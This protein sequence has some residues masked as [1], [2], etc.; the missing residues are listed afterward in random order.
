MILDVVEYFLDGLKMRSTYAVCIKPYISPG[1][2]FKIKIN[3]F[4]ARIPLCRSNKTSGKGG[5]SE[6]ECWS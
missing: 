4:N 5:S 1:E 6:D 3:T 2:I